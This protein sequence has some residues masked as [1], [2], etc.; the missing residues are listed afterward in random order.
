MA[1]ALYD[2]RVLRAYLSQRGHSKIA[3]VGMSL[4]GYVGA[5]W[6]SLD[7]LDRA[8]LLVPLVSMGDMAWN[9]L[10][11]QGEQSLPIEFLRSLFID[12]SPLERSP[13]TAESD[14]LVVGGTDDHLVPKAQINEIQARWPGVEV[15]W[16]AG[17]HGAVTD[18]RSVFDRISRFVRHG[19][20]GG[21]DDK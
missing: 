12:H 5:L 20:I 21:I 15:F 9:L 18:R 8:A 7:R 2:L 3:V 6:A 13:S 17:G 10:A 4:G 19:T 11:R 16:A 1:H 14:I